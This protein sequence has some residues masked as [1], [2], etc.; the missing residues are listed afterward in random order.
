M[1]SKLNTQELSGDVDRMH[2]NREK[3][4]QSILENKISTQRHTIFKMAMLDYLAMLSFE[5]GK[6]CR[7]KWTGREIFRRNA[8]LYVQRPRRK[9]DKASQTAVLVCQS[10]WLCLIGLH[11]H[12]CPIWYL[13]KSIRPQW[14]MHVHVR[15]VFLPNSPM[16]IS[17]HSPH[18]QN[19]ANS[20]HRVMCVTWCHACEL[21][22][23]RRLHSPISPV[24]RLQSWW[25][26]S[27]FS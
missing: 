24:L 9:I 6:W 21:C 19:N 3:D 23:L 25:V 11:F 26:C 14:Y 7:I 8:A 5:P 18:L 22:L 27:T 12:D 1:A 20:P 4:W 17:S 15:C 10:T 2:T 13:R 16:T